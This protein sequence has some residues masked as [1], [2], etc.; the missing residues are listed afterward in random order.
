M[1]IPENPGPARDDYILQAV[2]DGKLDFTYAYVTTS[3]NGHTGKFAVFAKPGK[4]DGIYV[5]VGARVL[6]QIADLLSCSLLTPKL[7]DTMWMQAQTR[8]LPYLAYDATRMQLT[9]WMQKATA[10]VDKL[11]ADAGYVAGNLAM[12]IGKP[13]QLSNALLEHPGRA[14]NY[15]LYVPKGKAPGQ[16]YF[17]VHAAQTVTPTD[18]YVLQDPGWAHGLTQDDY[19]ELI[20]LVSRQCEIDGKPADFSQVI[21]DPELAGLVSHEG[22]LKITR[23]PGVPVYACPLP[24]TAASYRMSP[25]TSPM[26]AGPGGNCPITPTGLP[27]VASGMGTTSPSKVVLAAGFV[28]GGAVVGAWA[29][30]KWRHRY[31]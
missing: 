30:R 26:T 9:S 27:G 6:Q 21:Q 1:P 11:L 5:G 22:P 28:L 4:I 29:L 18:A 10:G 8:I 19:S 3:Y 7:Q 31:L 16:N 17:G 13:W 24:K 25:M 20:S 23:Q 14:E 12:G 2:Q 15:G